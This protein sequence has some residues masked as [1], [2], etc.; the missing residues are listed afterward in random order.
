MALLAAVVVVPGA[1]IRIAA[2]EGSSD[3]KPATSPGSVAHQF[4]VYSMPA[5]PTVPPAAIGAGVAG[6]GDKAPVYYVV[7]KADDV[8]ANLR[9][10]WG[11]NE[12]KAKEFLSDRVKCLAADPT[13]ASAQRR[14]MKS[15]VWS[16]DGMVIGATNAGHKWVAD[17]LDVFRKFGTVQIAV[18][19]RFVTLSAEELQQAL[20][21]WTMS[22]LTVDEAALANSSA[23]E[24]ASFDRPL[25]DHEGTHVA[26]A[27][28]LIE[29]DSPVRV[30]VMD[31]EQ[32]EK[33]ITRCWSNV[34]QAPKFT[35]FN[36]QTTFV[37]DT[38]KSPFVVG[39][40]PVGPDAQMMPQI[41]QVSEGTMLQLR[42]AADRSG[43]IHLDFAATFSKVQDVDTVCFNRT[44]TSG[45]TLQIP[46]VATIRLE[47]G[48]V[49]KPG[50]W[51]L[52]AGSKAENEVG[53][54]DETPVWWADWL[55]GKGKRF[56]RAETQELV[57]MLRAEKVDTLNPKRIE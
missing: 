54:P 52:M 39:V 16:K 15:V 2:E 48:A 13:Y 14:D 40:I 17:A 12:S 55:F 30:R 7:Y 10:E 46:K 20:P 56:K 38:S 41:R 11:L 8:L 28:L 21:D 26:R 24:P 42:P 37:S 33:L 45:T 32:G 35:V 43:A 44:P 1:A 34:L 29:K 19:T 6:S 4:N 47:G 53:V 31:K 49:L 22:P 51:L 9:E 25:G 57:L 18:E 3:L 36:G 27:Q 5:E 50:Q 23:A